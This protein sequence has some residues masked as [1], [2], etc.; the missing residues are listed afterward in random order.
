[1]HCLGLLLLGSV[2]VCA[3][4]CGRTMLGSPVNPGGGSA[5]G[6]IAGTGAGGEDAQ[7]PM[8]A[9][10]VCKAAIATNC[11]RTRICVGD[12]VAGDCTRFANLCPDYY[13]SSDSK[14]TVDS[15]SACMAV[16]AARACSDYVLNFAPAC[17]PSGKLPAGSPCTYPSQCVSGSCAG[18][19]S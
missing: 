10:D 5:T 3:T 14:D 13:F 7:I 15:V 12:L 4:S 9:M 18:P 1:M 17:Y 6:G 2:L 8:S 11:A 19:S 16:L